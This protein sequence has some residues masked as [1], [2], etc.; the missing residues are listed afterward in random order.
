[1]TKREKQGDEWY[2]HQV[3]TVDGEILYCRGYPDKNSPGYN[4][5]I[6]SETVEATAVDPQAN[7]ATVTPP[8]APPEPPATDPIQD[9]NDLFFEDE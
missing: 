2:S 5:R 1:M 8:A 3:T 7:G 6:H 9:A 4:A